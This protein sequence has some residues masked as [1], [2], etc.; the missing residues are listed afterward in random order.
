MIGALRR[1]YPVRLAQ[2]YGQSQSSYYAAAL[3]F[4]AFVS[5]FPLILGLLAIVGL[6]LQSPQA[7]A[8][9]QTTVLAFFPPDAH[10]AL[11]SAMN[12]VRR[13]SGILGL[14]AIVGMVWSGSS[15]F[16]TLEFALGQVLGTG[17][18]GFLRQQ[19]MAFTMTAVFVLA[20]VLTVVVNAVAGLARGL[21]FAGPVIGAV[22]WVAFTL[23]IYRWVPNRSFRLGELWRGAVMAGVLMEILTLLWPLYVRLSH[24]FNTYGATFALFFL[25][26]AWLYFWAQLTL[27]GAVVNRFHTDRLEAAGAVHQ[28]DRGP[29]ETEAA[30]AIDEQARR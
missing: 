27:L 19:A 26:A 15:L 7:Q 21:P 30:R 22:I 17:R 10:A 20:I 23:V 11:Q 6:L 25:L 14:I 8:Q 16:T 29:V 24:G 4:K 18:R 13:A 28:P 5:M 9:A 3:A 12:G 2:A 1:T